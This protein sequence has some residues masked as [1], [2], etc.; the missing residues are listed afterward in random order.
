[1]KTF[2]VA[3]FVQRGKRG[4][5]F[6]AYTRWFNPSW[7]G[8]NMVRVRAENGTAAKKMAIN[9]IKARMNLKSMLPPSDVAVC[10]E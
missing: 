8:C 5:K 7:S 3:V 9:E 10:G 1:M 4:W 2:D 6:D